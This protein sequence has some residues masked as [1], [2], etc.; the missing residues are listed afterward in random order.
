MD[1]IFV[2]TGGSPISPIFAEKLVLDSEKKIP[3]VAA[4]SGIETFERFQEH[5]GG[6]F[7]LKKIVGDWD[8]IS[9]SSRLKK[10]PKEIICSM[11]VDKD[12]TDTELA[13][14]DAKKMGEGRTVVLVG[15]SAGERIDHFLGAFDLFST[16]IRADI[17]L[18]GFQTL[19]FLPEKSRVFIRPKHK[20]DVISI[21]RTSKSRSGGKIE[22]NGLFWE[23]DKFRKEGI[24]SLSNR[25][26]D[27][28]PIELFVFEGEF[29]LAVLSTTDVKIE[30]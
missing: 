27:E 28:N 26:L 17:W 9:D 23:S 29:V 5:F 11:P 12:F 1:S 10:Y 30:F 24:P 19:Y 6:V 8:S 20:N 21:L 22:S 18:C 13:L 4:D 3:A 16:K 7:L 2:F 25:A 15:A 14:E